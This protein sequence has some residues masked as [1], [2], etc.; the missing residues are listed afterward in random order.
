MELKTKAPEY[1]VCLDLVK[2]K[3]PAP[4]GLMTN[5]VWH[6]DPKRLVF[7]LSRYKFVEKIL[8]GAA[9]ALEVGCADAW[10]SRIFQQEVGSLTVSDSDPVFIKDVQTRT[11]DDWKFETL[12]HD[13]LA[14]PV[15]RKFDGV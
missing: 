14:G 1:Q 7:V 15:E 11:E 12:V 3:P 2:D 4:L 13:M 8:S 10:G 9:T 6:D 5:Q